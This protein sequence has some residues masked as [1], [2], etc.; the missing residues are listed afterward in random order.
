MVNETAVSY[1]ATTTGCA[2]KSDENDYGMTANNATTMLFRRRT[3]LKE[4]V[5][6]KSRLKQRRNV[7]CQDF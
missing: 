5:S 6:P 3:D 1:N 2:F 7:H 4:N